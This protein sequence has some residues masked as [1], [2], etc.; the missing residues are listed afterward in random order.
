M[1]LGLQPA[2][3][4]D[5]R[6][7]LRGDSSVLYF[8]LSDAVKEGGLVRFGPLPLPQGFVPLSAEIVVRLGAY[9]SAVLAAEQQIP[10]SP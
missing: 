1:W 4:A 10:T 3:L 2:E 5:W 6:L 8:D 9:T 7:K